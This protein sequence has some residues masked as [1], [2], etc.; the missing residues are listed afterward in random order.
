MVVV[1]NVCQMSESGGGTLEWARKYPLYA[2]LIIIDLHLD[3]P[4]TPIIHGPSPRSIG[5][6][7]FMAGPNYR[8][9]PVLA[10]PIGY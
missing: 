10:A 7:W 8:L 2:H 5:S 1:T 9:A 6:G 4:S 3:C